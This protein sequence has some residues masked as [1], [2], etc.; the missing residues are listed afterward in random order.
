MPK[1]NVLLLGAGFIADIHMECYHRFV[2]QAKVVGVFARNDQKA[3]AFAKRHGIPESYDDLHQAIAT[4]GCDVVDICLPNFLHHQAVLE[5]MC[6]AY[7]SARSGA[8]I[9]LPFTPHAPKPIDHW[10]GY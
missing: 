8:R 1:T 9:P 3:Q 6:A 5:I 7:A 2:P 10:L 4:S